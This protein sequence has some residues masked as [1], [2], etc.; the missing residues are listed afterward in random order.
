MAL[1]NCTTIAGADGRELKEHGL[2]FF[3]IAGYYDD[4]RLEAVPWHWHEELEA[5]VV[6]EGMAELYTTI[7]LKEFLSKPSFE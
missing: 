3:P 1:A 7:D 6:T 5:A 4:L 2:A